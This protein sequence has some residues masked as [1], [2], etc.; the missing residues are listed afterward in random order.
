MLES[1]DFHAEMR[2][3]WCAAGAKS[4]RDRLCRTGSRLQPASVFQRCVAN[5][6]ATDRDWPCARQLSSRMFWD[7]HDPRLLREPRRPDR[8]P[9][10]QAGAD[11]RQAFRRIDRTAHLLLEQPLEPGA[12]LQQSRGK[13]TQLGWIARQHISQITHW[14]EL[15][16]FAPRCSEDFM[17]YA[18]A[19]GCGIRDGCMRVQSMPARSA[20]SCAAFIRI[21]PSTTG[22]HLK[23]LPSSRFQYSTRPLPSQT[24]IFTRSARFARKTTATPF[25]GSWPSVSFAKSAKPSAPLRLCGAP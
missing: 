15:P 18:S 8:Y 5:A 19:F 20:D 7:W 9:P 17:P 21:T 6:P 23:A 10:E 3:P 12:A 24:T 1:R 25:I 4:Q 16:C 2:V 11:Q 13:G 14:P 22:S